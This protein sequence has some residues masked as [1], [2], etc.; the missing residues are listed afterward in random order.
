MTA[1][2]A[3]IREPG[4]SASVFVA[5]VDRLAR[6]HALPRAPC[7]TCH[8]RHC[9]VPA[10]LSPAQVEGLDRLPFSRRRVQLG[11]TLYEPGDVFK[12]LYAVR[13]GMFKSCVTLEDGRQQVTGF[14][15]P[16]ELLGLDGVATGR[17]ASSATALEDSEICAIPYADLRTTSSADLELQGAIARLMSREIVR[18]HSLMLMLGSMS[19]EERLAAFLLSLSTRMKVRGFSPI[20]FHLRMSRADIGSFLGLKLETVSR[21]FTSL[22]RQRLLHVDKKHVRILD[23]HL[24]RSALDMRTSP[25][26]AAGPHGDG[27][28]R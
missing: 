14:H 20:E 4:R 11:G 25:L 28:R 3:A 12:C 27:R 5:G 8:L 17:Y 23:L 22:V 1:D 13:N 6:P 15:L 7:S 16:G 19:A 10:G 18:E 2:T 21:T 9:C 26:R 24:L